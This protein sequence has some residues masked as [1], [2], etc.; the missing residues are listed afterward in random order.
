MFIANK[1]KERERGKREN[2]QKS[3][4]YKVKNLKTSYILPEGIF[5][6]LTSKFC[7][8][9]S[10]KE[11]SLAGLHCRLWTPSVSDWHSLPGQMTSNTGVL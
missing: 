9:C 2:G 6:D 4:T 5:A 10:M 11:E 7:E 3:T 8:I 1:Q